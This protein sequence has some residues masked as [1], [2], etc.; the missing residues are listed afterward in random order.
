M[1]VAFTASFGVPS[2]VEVVPPDIE[3]VRRVEGRV[4]GQN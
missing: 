2:P 3:T 1:T 4:E